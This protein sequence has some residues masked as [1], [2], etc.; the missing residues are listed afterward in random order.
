MIE[1]FTWSDSIPGTK[2][3]MEELFC[4]NVDAYKVFLIFYHS[5]GVW[6]DIQDSEVRSSED[7]TKMLNGLVHDLPQ[8]LFWQKYGNELYPLVWN[9]MISWQVAN[10]Y[11]KDKDEHGIEL[12]HMLRYSIAQVMCYIIHMLQ[13]RD[14]SKS[15]EIW[16]VMLKIFCHDRFETY[17]KEILEISE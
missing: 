7:V 3:S 8:N 11:E 14:V 10:S 4:G 12:G 6:D 9:A 1:K 17:R 15:V 5:S 16:K 2:Y 13:G